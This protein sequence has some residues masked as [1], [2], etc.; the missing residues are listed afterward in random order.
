MQYIMIYICETFSDRFHHV[1]APDHVPQPGVHD[2]P[3]RRP[4]VPPV[5]GVKVHQIP[6][7]QDPGAQ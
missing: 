7:G 2:Q 1:H 6:G 5:P 4:T 3:I